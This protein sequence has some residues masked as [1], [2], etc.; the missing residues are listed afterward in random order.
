MFN[1]YLNSQL[2][3]QFQEILR[4]YCETFYMRLQIGETTSRRKWVPFVVS[5][6]AVWVTVL[7]LNSVIQ[8]YTLYKAKKQQA[9][10]LNASADK[11]ADHQHSVGNTYSV[12]S[13]R[14][15][16]LTQRLRYTYQH[17]I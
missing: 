9:L 7:H 16:L 1:I 3:F 12:L 13:I 8:I 4:L 14:E 15:N 11:H 6:W 10:N 17:G 5:V 2:I